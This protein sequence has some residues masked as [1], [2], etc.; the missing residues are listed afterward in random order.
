V[1]TVAFVPVRGGSKSIPLKNIKQLAGKPLVAW[2]L[3][4]LQNASV[5]D[6]IVVATDSL[7][8]KRCVLGLGFSKVSVYDR[9]ASNAEDTSSTESVMLEYLG[10]AQLTVDDRFLLVQATSPFTTSADIDG[11]LAAYE[12]SEYDSMLSAVRTKRFFWNADGTPVNYD[13]RAR[14]RR[15][16]F[17]GLFMEN[18]ALYVNRVGNILRERNRLSGKVGVYAMPEYSALEIDEELDW[19]I[20]ENILHKE[21]HG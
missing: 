21:H 16:D 5:V 14:P 8:I 13:F 19:M 3:A 9:E 4:A 15:Q 12:C 11:M 20:A 10:K 1:K 7:E 18:G 6:S 2:S 17:D